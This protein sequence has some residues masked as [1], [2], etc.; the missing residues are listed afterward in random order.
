MKKWK[1]ALA[2]LLC[3][4]ILLGS[5][6]LMSVAAASGTK[7]V[8]SLPFI[9]ISD[10]HIFPDSE[11]GSRSD[12]WMEYCR[13]VAKM[14]NESETIIRTALTT[15][16]ERAKKTG[17]KYVLIPGDLTK[18]S[19]YAAHKCLANMLLEFEEKYGVQ[20]LVINGNHDIA[21]DA[22]CTFKKDKMQPA[23]SITYKEFAK[24]YKKLG[25]DLLAKSTKTLNARYSPTLEPIPGALSYV[26]DLGDDYRLIVVDSCKYSFDGPAKEQTDGMITEE[27]MQ[28]IEAWAK[29]T[30]DDGKVPIMMLHHALAAHMKTEPSITYAF[31]LDEYI[32]AAD[33]LAAAGIHYAFTGHLHT[34]DVACTINDDGDALYDVETDSVTGYPNTYRENKLVT[35]KNGQTKFSTKTVPF[36]NVAQ[37]K[38]DG[39]TY[40]KNSYCQKSFALCFG[41][42]LSEDG[43]PDATAF[44]LGLVKAFGGTFIDTINEAGGIL[45]YLKTLNIDLREILSNFLYPYIGNGVKIGGY[46]VFT[47]DNIL[48]FIEDLVDQ[49]SKLYLQDPDNLYAALK[50]IIEKLMTF[51]VSDIPCTKF[52]DTLH[53]GDK[54]CPGTLGDLVLSA[55]VYWFSGNEDPSDDAFLLDAIDGFDNRDTFERFFYFVVDIALNDIVDDMLLSHL[56]IRLGKLFGNKFL[57]KQAG[58]GLNYLVKQLL[59]GD[60]TYMNLVNIVF[61]LDVLPYKD[62]YDVLDQ[63]LFQKYLTPSLFEGMGQFVAYVLNDFSSDTNPKFKGD[64]RVVYTSDKVAVEATQQNYRLPTM[65]SVTMGKDSKTQATIGWFSKY[66]LP[67]TDF[68]IY[69]ADSEPAFKGKSN[70]LSGVKIKKTSELVDR[71]FPGIDLDIT[72][73]LWYMFK[74]QRH[75][76]K[77]SGLEPGAT[78]YYRV[79]NAQYG[80]WSP[81]GVLRTADGSNDVTFLHLSDQQSQNERQYNECWVPV[82]KSAFAT[83]DGKIDFIAD[84]G[85]LVDHG[86]NNRQWQAMFDTGAPYLQNTFLMPATGNHGGYGTNATMNYFVLPNVPQ[87]DTESGV[88]YS[89]DYNN[90]HVSV[91]NT[92]ALNDDNALTDEQ[93]AWL[94]K[95]VKKS[96]DAD[97]H[98]VMFHKALYSHGSHYKD[99]DIIA[100]R[101]QLGTLMPQLGIDVVLT[102]HDHVYLRTASLVGN[103]KVATTYTYL[104]KDGDIYK[105]QVQPTGTTYMISGTAGVK[106]YKANDTS[107]TDEYFPRG[108]KILTLDTPMYS[109]YEIRD[110][111]LYMKAYTVKDGETVVMDSFAIQKDPSEGTVVDYTEEVTPETE[112]TKL[113]TFMQKVKDVMEI[114]SKLMVN[115][116]R[117][118]VLRVPV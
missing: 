2:L 47:V 30:Y 78:Y 24:V 18:D 102:G 15:A 62:L 87:Q 51:E 34:T 56:E 65:L 12:T 109:A 90:V 39:V 14:F 63:L 41:G 54:D 1:K 92:E 118:Y 17:A 59:R 20:F 61:A 64:D 77:L 22:A 35:L 52:L 117:I 66:S 69:K 3:L 103:E 113:E 21:N 72:G 86:D 53:F 57:M 107:K 32:E 7:V 83:Y 50:P 75:T 33:R 82:L 42:G 111:V 37:M 95:D 89:F 5:A 112:P 91:L 98:F 100:M 10:P 27:L 94:K 71:Q 108:E 31:V 28:W 96:A 70:K 105:T 44:A 116:T 67:A 99:K 110:K 8:S 88:Y 106:F 74:L 73:V 93:I 49:I 40:P 4:C 29:K 60:N 38:F 101:E 115:L 81:T 6:Q 58:D 55:M 26:A 48:W 19:E 43:N 114:F 79:G 11:Q 23:R 84:A 25:Y 16:C 80:W 97:W 46:K 104:E 85:D 76:V 13:L 68:E 9:T 45:A 36:D